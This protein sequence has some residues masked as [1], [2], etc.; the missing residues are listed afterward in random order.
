MSA[1]QYLYETIELPEYHFMFNLYQQD[2]VIIIKPY[3][4][5]NLTL[6]EWLLNSGAYMHSIWAMPFW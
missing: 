4:T 5:S 3:L 2:D 6:S 1:Q